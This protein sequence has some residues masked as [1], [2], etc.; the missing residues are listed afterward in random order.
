MRDI[1]MPVSVS[2]ALLDQEAMETNVGA[3]ILT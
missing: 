1:A 2:A 3:L